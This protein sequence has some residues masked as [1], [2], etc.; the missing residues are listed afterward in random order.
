MVS[1]LRNSLLICVI[2]SVYPTQSI[3]Y[4]IYYYFVHLCIS[5]SVV[6]T[7]R[8]KIFNIKEIKILTVA[9]SQLLFLIK[10]RH[11][12]RKCVKRENS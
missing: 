12:L 6:F 10:I 9:T 1:N 3:N 4:T 7:V 5:I 11:F 2:M 8:A